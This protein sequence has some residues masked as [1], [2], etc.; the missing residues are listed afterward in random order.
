MQS[1]GA[2]NI[3]RFHA[4]RRLLIESIRSAVWIA[5]VSC[6]LWWL[7]RYHATPGSVGQTPT[8]LPADV[9]GVFLPGRTRLLMFVH[10]RCPCSRAS[11]AQ[12]AEIVAQ[13]KGRVAAAIVFVKPPGAAPDWERSSL[14]DAAVKIRGARVMCDDGTLARRLGAETSGHVMLYDADGR[15]LFSGGITRSRG[16]EGVSSGGRAICRLLHGETTS[17]S[18][19]PVFGCPLFNPGRCARPNQSFAIET[20]DQQCPPDTR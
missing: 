20:Q 1:I 13:N 12:L 3:D 6:G 4:A 5:A 2:V 14:W 9:S 11:L 7:N 8:S 15:L 10:P 18:T 16:H 19:M 17:D